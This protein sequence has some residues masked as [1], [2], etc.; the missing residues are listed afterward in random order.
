MGGITIFP[1][2]VTPAQL[3][4]SVLLL[5]PLNG[6]RAMTGDIKFPDYTGLADSNGNDVLQVIKTASATKYFT[7]TNAA[8]GSPTLSVDDGAGGNVDLTILG[9]GE[10]SIV[11]NT[12]VAVGF[13]G[14]LVASNGASLSGT[15][16]FGSLT[17]T[18][19]PYIDA[20]NNLVSSAVT[21]T[22]LG[23]L[24][25]TTGTT[26]TGALVLATTPTLVTPVLGVA[27]ATS[28]NGLSFTSS[29]TVTTAGQTVTVN[30]TT[31]VTLFGTGVTGGASDSTIFGNGKSGTASTKATLFG[32]NLNTAGTAANA[33]YWFG[34]DINTT[35]SGSSIAMGKTINMNATGIVALLPNSGNVTYTITGAGAVVIGDLISLGTSIGN[36]VI[37]GKSAIA[38]DNQTQMTIIGVG[39][40]GFLDPSFGS[41]GSGQ[42]AIGESTFAGAWRATA[43][44]S[45]AQALAVSTTG[46]GYGCQVTGAH[47][48]VYGRGG[49]NPLGAATVFYNGVS[50]F[51]FYFGA[52]GSTWTNSAMPGSETPDLS[53]GLNAG[54]TVTRLIGIPGKDYK[55]TPTLTD[56]RGGH[57]Q[58]EGGASTGTAVGG[59]VRLATSPASGASSNNLNAQVVMLTVKGDYTINF[60]AE[61]TSLFN[62]T[63][64]PVAPGANQFAIY[65]ADQ[66]AGNAALHVKTENA[67][68][69]KIYSVGGWGTPS[70]TLTRTTFDTSTVTL[71]ELAERVAALLSDLKTGHQLLKA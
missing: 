70:G 54:T 25:G 37:I 38:A 28:L 4:A 2:A 65:S 33:I 57:V 36:S 3:D 35:G 46:Y 66:T 19:V 43:V 7:L 32:S 11:L 41:S 30:G 5:L 12:N 14:N 34:T 71:P 48:S 51:D 67:D 18:T 50:G 24:S 61:T 10:G 1:D 15:V 20:S 8:V 59:E 42:V 22:Q 64:S 29:A 68:I 17:A 6:E 60:A 45:Y 56:I 31:R 23:Y 40:K 62:N 16:N 13:A 69:I 47:G 49:Y 26:G 44:G 55:P 53:T 58:L 27:T 63:A 21:P 9:S 39:A 52:V